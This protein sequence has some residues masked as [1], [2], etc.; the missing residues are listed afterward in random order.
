MGSLVDL[1]M[2]LLVPSVLGLRCPFLKPRVRVEN[3]DITLEAFS[4][5]LIALAEPGNHGN[6]AHN[7]VLR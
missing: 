7:E 1:A 3:P 5:M 2:W 4:V 6:D